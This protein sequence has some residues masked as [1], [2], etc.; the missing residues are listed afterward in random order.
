MIELSNY[1]LVFRF[2]E[3]HADVRYR[4]DFERTLRIPDD[5]R[6]YP[7]TPGLGRLPVRPPGRLMRQPIHEDDDEGGGVLG[8]NESLVPHHVVPLGRAQPV[9]EGEL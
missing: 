9:R 7:L 2:P 1:G 4:I 5:N 3:V 8:G 6:D